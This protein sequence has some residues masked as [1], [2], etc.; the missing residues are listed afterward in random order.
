MS[1]MI[2]VGLV[3]ALV[4]RMSVVKV[5]VLVAGLLSTVAGSGMAVVASYVV[6]LL[7]V[8]RIGNLRRYALPALLVIGPFTTTVFGQAVSE[9]VLEFGEPR[10]S[11][12]L[13]AIEP[14][15]QLLPFWVSDPVSVV[16]GQGPGSS[17]E[18]IRG[19]AING[20]LVPSTAKVLFDYGLVGG[21]GLIILMIFT[22]VRSPE[23]LF[24]LSMAAS[25]FV[26]QTASQPLVICSI[27][28]FAF[29]SPAPNNHLVDSEKY[30]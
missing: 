20:L 4:T 13:R 7:L 12:S 3:S 30:P 29:W 25:M 27:M 14:Y 22:Y 23:P 15:I 24:A 8:G 6:C 17:A 2:A 19:L 16:I 18:I 10:S 11:T 21:T 26:L 1:F 28:L 5:L 9:R